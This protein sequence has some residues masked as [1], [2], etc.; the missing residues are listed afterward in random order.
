MT[1][2][3]TLKFTNA[4]KWMPLLL[5]LTACAGGMQQNDVWS[6]MDYSSVYR[7][8]G[9]RENDNSYKAPTIINCVDD[10]LYNCNPR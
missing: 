1:A 5:L 3:H 7:K 8:A 10:D 9:Q 2:T 4:D 6:D